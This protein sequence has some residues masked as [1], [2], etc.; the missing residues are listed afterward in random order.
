MRI[1]LPYEVSCSAEAVEKHTRHLGAQGLGSIAAALLL[2]CVF[3]A[4]LCGAGG[5]DG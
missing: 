2:S 4:A 1:K 5:E 3:P